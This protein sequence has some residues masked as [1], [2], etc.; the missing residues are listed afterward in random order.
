[1]D[2]RHRPA[3]FGAAGLFLAALLAG[4]DS[5]VGK[6]PS[7]SGDAKADAALLSTLAEDRANPKALARHFAQGAAPKPADLKRY[8]KYGFYLG[9]KPAVNGDTATLTVVIHDESAGKEVG[10][11]DWT[12]VKE[13]SEWKLKSAPLP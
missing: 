12:F 13:G 11:L 5:S 7:L 9:G 2:P 10:K 1:M 8:A 3:A 4:C 6:P